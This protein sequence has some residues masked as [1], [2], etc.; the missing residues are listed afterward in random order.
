M[1]RGLANAVDGFEFH[2]SFHD[3]GT[4]TV[5]GVAIPANGGI[6]DGLTMID[7]LAHHPDTAR[8]ISRKLIVR[9]VSETPPPRLLD[10]AT[11]AFLGSGG[12]IRA[13]LE[14]IFQSPEFLTAPQYRHA[15]VKRPLH[16]FA[17]VVRALGADPTTMNTEH[18]PKPH[19]SARRGPLRLGAADGLPDVSPFWISPGTAVRRFNETEAMSRGSYGF[20]FTY[21]VAGGTSAQIVD[22]L[23]ARAVPRTVST[24]RAVRRSASSTCCPSPMPPSGSSRPRRSCSRAPSSSPTERRGHGDD[25]HAKAIHPVSDRRHDG[26]P[27]AVVGTPGPRGGTDPVVVSIF[28]RGAA[29]GL[30][31]V[32]P[33]DDPFYYSSRPTVQIAPGSELPLDSFFGLNPAFADLKTLYDGGSLAFLH[34]AGSPD[35]SRSHFD[36]QDFMDR[37]APGNKSIV[38]GWLNRYLGVAGGG[39]PIAGISLSSA[40]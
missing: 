35:P 5:M 3:Q 25:V 10:E 38:D 2:A 29:D 9:F 14:T 24:T 27:V 8:F 32:V 1:G 40:A 16:F 22:A 19:R 15:K 28:Q 18:S 39:Q 23:T 20:V 37:A 36:A 17:S 21:P 26:V 33:V 4:K 12:D 11:G 34:A 13:V 6:N 31:T 30:N 7:F